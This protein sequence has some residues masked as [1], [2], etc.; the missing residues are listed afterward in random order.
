MIE[1]LAHLSKTCICGVATGPTNFGRLD[2]SSGK[3]ASTSPAMHLNREPEETHADDDDGH[4]ERP[5][6]SRDGDKNGDE[7]SSA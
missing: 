3:S 6:T 4:Q 2:A 5:Q 1:Q 7:E